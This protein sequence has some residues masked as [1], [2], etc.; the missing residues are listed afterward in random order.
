MAGRRTKLTIEI[1]QQ[2]VAFIRA[3]TYDWIA[4]E[5]AGIGKSTF[6]R[7]LARGARE[8]RGPYREFHDAVRQARAQARVAAETEVR[9]D[10]PLAW[11]RYGPGRE[12]APARPAGPRATRSRARMAARCA[13]PCSWGGSPPP[14]RTAMSEPAAFIYERPPLYPKQEAAIFHPARYAV[15]EA[16]TKAGKTFG[17]LVWLFERA[18]S[19]GPGTHY[20]WLAPVQSQARIAYMRLKG[21]M[22]PPPP[23][24]PPRGGGSSGPARAITRSRSAT[25]R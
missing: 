23:L 5:A 8:A 17:C 10:Q 3:G 6:Y 2:I 25:G 15:V 16:S 11:L 20:W 22:P 4:A 14:R 12:S 7:W 1:H 19:G 21:G 9:R 18:L 24:P 13:S